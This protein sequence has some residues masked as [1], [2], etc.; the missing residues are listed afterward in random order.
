MIT[1]PAAFDQ[2]QKNATMAAAEMA[3]IG[4]VELVQEPVAAV[5]SYMKARGGSDGIFLIYDFGGGTLDIAIAESIRKRVA[6]LAQGGIQM[7]G[8]RDFDR[9]L[10]DNHCPTLARM[11]ILTLPD[12]ISVNPKYKPLLR[13]ATWATERAKIEL[14][15]RDESD[16]KS[17]RS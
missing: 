9:T 2:M 12:D 8:G 10:V 7:C 4:K 3:G 6:I 5:M 15:A 13:L 17:F 11:K 16:D 14:S 1:V